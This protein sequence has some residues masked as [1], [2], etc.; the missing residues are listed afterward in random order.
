MHVVVFL[1]AQ[2]HKIPAQ[3]QE[4]F[5]N[6]ECNQ[7]LDIKEKFVDARSK[8][9]SIVVKFEERLLEDKKKMMKVTNIYKHE[10]VDTRA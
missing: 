4:F 3:L 7:C 9:T 1:G 6:K 10:I 5:V 2:R 8:S